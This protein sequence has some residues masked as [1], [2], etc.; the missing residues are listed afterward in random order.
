[1]KTLLFVVMSLALSS[2]ASSGSAGGAMTQAECIARVDVLKA[3]AAAAWAA[4]EPAKE[5]A[6]NNPDS[7]DAK[8][9]AETATR[10]AA[11]VAVDSAQAAADL[12]IGP[13]KGMF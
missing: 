8:I 10:K 13:C 7:A 2:C 6:R 11:G 9:A 4:A 5:F 12:G 1:M 3:N